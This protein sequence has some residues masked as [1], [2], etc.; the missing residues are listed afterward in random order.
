MKIMIL[1]VRLDSVIL[2]LFGSHETTP[3][4]CAKISCEFDCLSKRHRGKL[5]TAKSFIMLLRV[6]LCADGMVGV[7]LNEWQQGVNC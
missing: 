7:V 6:T 2:C 4:F 1:K 3:R 5:S